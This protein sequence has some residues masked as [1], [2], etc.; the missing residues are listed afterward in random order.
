M[1]NVNILLLLRSCIASTL[2]L[3]EIDILFVHHVRFCVFDDGKRKY[4]VG[5]LAM[6]YAFLL[7]WLLDIHHEI[8]HTL[9]LERTF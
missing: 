7:D 2:Q 1:S 6:V 5:A 9:H 8:F 4:L 3:E